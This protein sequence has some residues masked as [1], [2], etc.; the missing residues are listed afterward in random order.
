MNLSPYKYEWNTF[1]RLTKMVERKNSKYRLVLRCDGSHPRSWKFSFE[2]YKD[3]KLVEKYDD[4][5]TQ[6]FYMQASQNQQQYKIESLGSVEFLTY[7]PERKRMS[8]LK[9]C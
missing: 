6:E 3:N 4:C 2:L 8:N 1:M 9:P 5:L 7:I